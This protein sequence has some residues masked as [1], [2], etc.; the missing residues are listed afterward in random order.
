MTENKNKIKESRQ[1]KCD[2][3]GEQQYQHRWLKTAALLLK[4]SLLS[5]SK[6][7]Q[8]RS[9]TRTELQIKAISKTT[10]RHER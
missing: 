7:T 4:I 3:T 9:I 6:H 2:M 5:T 1:K 8:V 10:P